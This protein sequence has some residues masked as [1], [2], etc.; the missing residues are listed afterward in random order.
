MNSF[1]MNIDYEKSISHYSDVSSYLE[2]NNYK[3]PEFSDIGSK[4]ETVE[5]NSEHFFQCKELKHLLELQPCNTELLDLARSLI[6]QGIDG[7][8]LNK[9]DKTR[10]YFR[11]LKE[12]GS[13]Y[14]SDFLTCPNFILIKESDDTKNGEAS[15]NFGK[16]NGGYYELLHEYLVLNELNK[17]RNYNPH[18]IYVWCQETCGS[19]FGNHFCVETEDP[20]R[21][22]YLENFPSMRLKDYLDICDKKEFLNIFL[23][24]VL[25]LKDINS[26]CNFTHYNLL[27]KN[28]LVRKLENNVQIHYGEY[29]LK[30]DRVVTLCGM[31]YSYFKKG[32]I[33]FSNPGYIEYGIYP[34][35]NYPLTDI[36]KFLLS[37]SIHLRKREDI[38]G[39]CSKLYEYF[40]DQSLEKTLN[41]LKIIS[42]P[43]DEKI[44]S[45]EVKSLF[46]DIILYCLKFSE[47]NFISK[48]SFVLPYLN[49]EQG[50]LDSSEI[51]I[52]LQ[53]GQINVNNILEFVEL[54]NKLDEKEKA[55]LKGK[56]P[57]YDAIKSLSN[58]LTSLLNNISLDKN[59]LHIFNFKDIS[60]DQLLKPETLQLAKDSYSKISKMLSDIDKFKTFYKVG[61]EACKIYNSPTDIIDYIYKN[62][63]NETEVLFNNIIT[64]LTGNSDTL[65]KLKE[66]PRVKEV[67]NKFSWFWKDR[68]TQD[69]IIEKTIK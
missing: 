69:K 59:N 39:M 14:V 28:I 55:V 38:F 61:I 23:Q 68:E 10:L 18:F 51:K 64:K 60:V 53:L 26:K 3:K 47:A 19:V 42:L 30:T 44:E 13:Y 21:Y 9:Y 1:G 32:Q 4:I 56:F 54:Y 29:F 2:K 58:E 31:E 17:F 62:Y 65:N 43:Y 40:S 45:I 34:N 37:C 35:F 22:L 67:I 5:K 7:I 57:F 16:N 8:F 41:N 27:I 63:K 33:E 52:R 11:N 6:S 15:L 25:A 66:N 50:C 46:D 12:F 49:C 20:V 24:V 36:Y 48:S